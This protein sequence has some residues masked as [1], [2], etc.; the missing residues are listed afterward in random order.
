MAARVCLS[1]VFCLAIARSGLSADPR[2]AT[3]PDEA[4]VIASLSS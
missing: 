4:F 2:K 1:L 3:R